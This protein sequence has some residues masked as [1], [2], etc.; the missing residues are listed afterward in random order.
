MSRTKPGK[1]QADNAMRRRLTLEANAGPA[2][3][4]TSLTRMGTAIGPAG[5]HLAE[6]EERSDGTKRSHPKPPELRR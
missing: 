6:D 2:G 5:N 4:T 3:T 1:G